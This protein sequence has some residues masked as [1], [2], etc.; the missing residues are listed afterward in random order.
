[1]YLTMLKNQFE[2]KWIKWIDRLIVIEYGGIYLMII[3]MNYQLIQQVYQCWNAL[4][5]KRY[6]SCFEVKN[7]RPLKHLDNF[8]L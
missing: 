4:P 6:N 2:K 1:M 8:I 7:N 5:N 3:Y